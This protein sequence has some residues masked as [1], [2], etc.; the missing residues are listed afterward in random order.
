MTASSYTVQ[1]TY[2]IKV[3][4]CKNK[5]EAHDRIEKLFTH[6]Q[7]DAFTIDGVEVKEA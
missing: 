3:T 6:L 4:G 2:A 1:G 7:V 5:H